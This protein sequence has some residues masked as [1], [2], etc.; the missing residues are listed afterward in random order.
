MMKNKEQ[1][2]IGGIILAVAA[3][4]LIIV[5]FINQPQ[6]TRSSA[7][8]TSLTP[9]PTSTCQTP[10]GVQNVRIDYPYCQGSACSSTQA[11]CSW[12]AVT[13]AVSYTVKVT[14]IETGTIVK[15]NQ[16]I[17]APP[18]TLVFSINNG[19]TYQCDVAATNAC[20]TSGQIGTDQRLCETAVVATPVPTATPAPTT[21]QPTATPVPTLTTTVIA[22]TNTPVPTIASPGSGTAAMIGTAGAIVT[23]IGI[24]LFFLSGL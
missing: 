18:L 19:K 5:S 10:G 7:Q 11:S 24:A 6:D 12:D 17:T 13:G 16:I 8:E 2:A 3:A 14:E 1:I 4:I 15:N 9:T 23:V 22:P 20:G 21:T